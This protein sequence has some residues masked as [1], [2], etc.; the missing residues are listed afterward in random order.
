[1]HVQELE[2]VRTLDDR[3]KPLFCDADRLAGPLLRISL[4]GLEVIAGVLLLVGHRVRYVAARDA[5][6]QKELRP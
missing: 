1:M 4:G 2:L 5:A 3:L 6:S